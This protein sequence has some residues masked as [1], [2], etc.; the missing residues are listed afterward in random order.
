MNK[1]H[2]LI[3][4]MD[5]YLMRFNVNTGLMQS[6][7][8]YTADEFVCK[9]DERMLKLKEEYGDDVVVTFDRN[10]NS[11]NCV[12]RYYIDYNGNDIKNI[13]AYYDY[14]LKD[15]QCWK[16]HFYRRI[17]CIVQTIQAIHVVFEH[18]N[19]PGMMD[20]TVTYNHINDDGTES[21]AF[22]VKSKT[23][24]DYVRVIKVYDKNDAFVAQLAFDKWSRPIESRCR[25]SVKQNILDKE[26]KRDY[27]AFIESIMNEIIDSNISDPE[28]E[29]EVYLLKEK[30]LRSNIMEWDTI[31]DE[32]ILLPASMLMSNN[33]YD[34]YESALDMLN[35]WF[36]VAIKIDNTEISDKIAAISETLRNYMVTTEEYGKDSM[37]YLRMIMTDSGPII[38]TY[39]LVSR[40]Q[41]NIL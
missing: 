6:N 16:I 8:P 22:S 36:N 10:E 19:C 13:E 35:K 27:E 37:I 14:D 24:K 39:D 28:L 29:E 1:C 34:K 12:L 7:I 20:S 15:N 26:Y 21:V 31:A 11:N 23:K 3:P 4:N 33:K 9:F 25:R 30:M 5:D 18:S 40:R 17:S 32:A 2:S 41:V 38:K